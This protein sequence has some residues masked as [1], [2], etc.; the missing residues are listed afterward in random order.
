MSLSYPDESLACNNCVKTDRPLIERK[1]I[2][3]GDK[4]NIEISED[5]LLLIIKGSVDISYEKISNERVDDGHI[6]LFSK[7]CKASIYAV[8][9]TSLII[10]RLYYQM[11]FCRKI[12]HKQMFEET[13]KESSHLSDNANSVI[14][15]YSGGNYILDMKSSVKAYADNLYER[16]ADGMECAD[17]FD[18][19]INELLLLLVA[20]YKEGD[21]LKFFA[22]LIHADLEFSNMVLNNYRKAKTVR[23]LAGL[24]NYS[25]SG[26][27]KRFKKVFN[28]S[29]GYWLKQKK[30]SELYYEISTGNVPF[31]T[32]SSQHGFSSLSNFNNY[33]R[34]HFGKT[35]GEIRKQNKG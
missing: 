32:L 30:S 28:V 5:K 9:K 27:E 29:A 34:L 25:A 17:F 13:K 35:P 23:E 3:E 31:K 8:T 19:K 1:I 4:W 10:V 18:L 6:L 12:A 2:G 26:F 22:P 16:L 33:C 21:L 11:D 20:Y 7:G 24:V 14:T 15:R